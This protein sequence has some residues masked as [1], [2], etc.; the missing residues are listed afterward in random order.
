MEKQFPQNGIAIEYLGE[1]RREKATAG[2]ILH[3][4][5]TKVEQFRTHMGRS[6]CVYKVGLTSNPLVRF[7]F[8]L[9]GNYTRMSLLHVTGNMGEAQMLE[10][11]LIEKNLLEK[12]CRNE[13]FGG[14]GPKHLREEPFHFVYIVGARADRLKAIRWGNQICNYFVRSS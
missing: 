7:Q 13:K 1:S 12:G 3:R 8:Y 5:F 10:A 14:D 2:T 9:E 6:V 4:C 11:A